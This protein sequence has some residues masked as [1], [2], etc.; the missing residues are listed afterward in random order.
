MFTGI[1]SKLVKSIEASNIFESYK[2]GHSYFDAWLKSQNL[3]RSV[4]HGSDNFIGNHAEQ[5]LEK[6]ETLEKL[7][8]Q[9]FKDD[10][11]RLQMARSFILCFKMF[12]TVVKGC[13]GVRPLK[14]DYEDDIRIFIE[15]FR[16]LGLKLSLKMHILDRHTSEFLKM[17]NEKHSL[18]H[19]SEQAM[20][21]CH[22][23]LKKE[24]RA[25]A[26][27]SV[28]HANYGAKLE[29]VMIRVTRKHM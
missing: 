14:P 15:T 2:V 26:I 12:R 24:L 13:F 5:I 20:E 23:E 21:S 9:D 18:G 8:E 19:F 28:D 3:E 7:L 4:Y 25:E 11:D 6:I 29:R 22:Q 10:E 16:G 17:F 1:V 27:V